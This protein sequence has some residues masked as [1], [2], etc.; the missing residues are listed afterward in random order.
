MAALSA[1]SLVFIRN[2]FYGALLL[3]VCLLSV[4][5]IYVLAFAEF[6]AI[7]QILIYVGGILV[8]IL[9]GIMLTSK[10]S[11]QPLVVQHANWISG[12]L[13]GGSFFT[14]LIYFL[15]QQVFERKENITTATPYHT[16]NKIGIGLMSDF[17]VP[18]EIAG[19]LLL[20][21][22]IGA[23]VTASSVKSKKV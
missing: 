1:I 8:V 14:I 9:F 15:S 21:A 3:I 4:A 23:A 5:G 19:I 2:V 20:V 16:V 12:F 13:V 11:N 17:V 18:F 10:I 7:T 6:V 22:L